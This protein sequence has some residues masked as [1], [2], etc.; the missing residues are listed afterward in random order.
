MLI[1]NYMA[2]TKK[3]ASK[4]NRSGVQQASKGSKKKLLNGGVDP[5]VG[6]ETQFKEGQ[7]G[8]PNGRPPGRISL[9]VHIQNLLNDDTFSAWLPDAREGYKEFKGVPIKAII[10]TAITRAIAG[11]TK[12]MDWLAKYGY[13]VKIDPG[14]AGDVVPVALVRLVDS[15]SADSRNQLPQ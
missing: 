6:K 1:S 10:Q 5:G 15:G 9:S 13:G 11:D 12:C 4:P 3:Q 7:S 14:D 8:N 2:E